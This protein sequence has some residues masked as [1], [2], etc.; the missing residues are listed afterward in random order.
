MPRALSADEVRILWEQGEIAL[1]DV[2]EA[3][4][5]RS[6]HIPGA[7][8]YPLTRML[9]GTTGVP[10]GRQIVVYCA[11]GHRSAVAAAVLRRRGHNDVAHLRGGLAAWTGPRRRS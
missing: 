8:L 3:V 10:T 7:T 5:Y 11:T 4:E 9:V 1:V 2:R 6:S